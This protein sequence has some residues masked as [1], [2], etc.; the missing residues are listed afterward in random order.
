MKILGILIGI[1][2][3]FVFSIP[4]FAGIFNFGSLAGI[5]LSLPL[6]LAGL[7]DS[8]LRELCADVS[9]VRILCRLVQCGYLVFLAIAVIT[10]ACMIKETRNTPEEDKE[11]TMVVLGCGL[12]GDQPSLM[13]WY[14]LKRAEAYL[15]DHP[16]MKVVVSGGQGGDEIMPEA[17]CM[18]QWL[19]NHGITEDRVY[20]EERSRSTAENLRYTMEIIKENHLPEEIIIVTNDFHAYR[21]GYIAKKQGIKH[22]TLA[23]HSTWWL[24]PISVLREVFGIAWE[25]V[26]R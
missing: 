13:L 17:R 18:K 21:A 10:C 7:F 11:Y 6:L 23:G 2:G 15:K 14:R 19:L 1:T 24:Y 5:L 8:R 22:R 4:L 16:E 3:L 12:E 9:W 26:K 25:W 20:S